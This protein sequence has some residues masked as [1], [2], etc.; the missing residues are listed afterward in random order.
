MTASTLLQVLRD[1]G[2]RLLVE[3]LDLV[4]DAPAGVLTHAD[5]DALAASKPA[6]LA[7]LREEITLDVPDGPCG[8]CGAPLAW[9]EDWPA[10]GEHRWLCL[11]CPAR[12]VPTLGEVYAT[13]S[14]EERDRLREEAAH[15]DDLSRGILNELE[16]ADPA[17]TT[18]A[19]R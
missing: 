10:T 19:R 11:T 9:I 4:V 1:R 2:V 8:L 5:W 18:R 12:P 13:L 14:D 17:A 6:L 3:G 7:L 15:G 16:P